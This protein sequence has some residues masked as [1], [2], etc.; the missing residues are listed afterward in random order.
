MKNDQILLAKLDRFIK[1]YYRNKLIRGIILSGAA[2]GAL[3]LSLVFI[4][5]LFH[6]NQGVRGI[7][8][9]GYIITALLLLIRQVFVPLV[10][11]LRYGK[12]ISYDQ[13]AT[14]IGEHFDEIRD[15][16]LNTLQ[17]IRES[18]K[19]A[20][21]SELLEASIDQKTERLKLIP[22]STA[23]DLKKN[24]KYLKFLLVQM[25]LISIVALVSPKIIS[26][27]THRI[28]QFTRS[29]EQPPKFSFQVL[30]KEL[31]V[32]QQDDLT[33]QVKVTGDELPGEVYLHTG[34]GQ[35]KMKKEKGIFF[36]YTF[37]SLQSSLQFEL[38]G[39]D[40]RSG[41]YT[42][43]V[44][45]KPII[46]NFQIE[47]TYP[48]HVNKPQETFDNVGDLFIPEGTVVTWTF[49]TKDVSELKMKFSNE[50]VDLLKN[51]G[52]TFTYSRRFLVSDHYSILP[53]NKFTYKPD[54]LSYKISVIND[55]YPSIAVTQEEDSTLM[56]LIFFQGVIK[57]D[58]GF[59]KMQ[60]GLETRQEG[61]TTM[62][63]NQRID[64]HVM[65]A[66]SSQQF[67]YT[68]DLTEYLIEHG[69]VVT[70]YFEVWDN[71]GVNGPK[72]SRT[73]KITI[74]LPTIEEI[75]S[76]TEKAE[77][78]IEKTFEAGLE[79]SKDIRKEI[80]E[81]NKKM[82]EKN[83]MSWQEKQKM[84]E[85][86]KA[87]E[88]ILKNIENIKEQNLKNIENEKRYLNTS[89][90]ILEKQKD[91]NALM[92]QLLTDEMKK[93][94]E[95]MKKLLGEMDK[96]KLGDLIEKMK[97]NNEDIEKQ[98]DRSLEIF[99]QIEFDRKI[100]KLIG[101]IRENAE[102]QEKAAEQTKKG[103]NK[104]EGEKEQKKVK[105][106]FDSISANLEKLTK[107]SELVENKPDMDKALEKQ[108][109]IEKKLKSIDRKMQEKK[110]KGTEKEQNEAAQ[111]M[112]EL[113]MEMEQSMEEDEMEQAEE[114]AGAI[115]MIL[116]NLVRLSH[117]QETLIKTTQVISK[118]DPRYNSMVERQ[119][120]MND[121][122]KGSEDSLNEIAKR[123]VLLQP[124]ISREIAAI[125]NNISLAIESMGNRML[126][127][128]VVQQQLVMTSI[129][130]LALLLNESLDKMN[131]QME[132][133]MSG[134]GKKSACKKPG[135][136]G[137]KGSMKNMKS[138]QQKL[139]E[140][141]EQL[142]SGM[143]KAKKE[144]KGDKLNETS[145]SRQ[146]AKLAAE[147]EF[148]RNE[149]QKHRDDMMEQGINDGGALKEVLKNMELNETDLI[150]KRISQ[151]TIKRQQMILTRMLE[152]EKAEQMREREEKRE[153]TEAKSR[154]YS[155]HFANLKYKVKGK[156][157]QDLL[158]LILP[159][160]NPYY[161]RKVNEYI[162]KIDR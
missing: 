68:M 79:K 26:E 88:T 12:I 1:K 113:A 157:E 145:M 75:E 60:V 92:D 45:P 7:F 50:I 41:E 137:G 61:D 116:E 149:M 84:E 129:N 82:V 4:E 122:L 103:N 95:E 39:G 16:L 130:N 148:L 156:N 24:L 72:S 69:E 63:K 56:H 112:N 81:L 21:K 32:M 126:K 140:Q 97:I 3:Y 34:G 14:I 87:H 94:M 150:N 36:S 48:K 47:A 74:A 159:G 83:T 13:A 155:N 66:L 55:G 152:S 125:R 19:G 124:V 153:S 85:I 70:C 31:T 93:L 76:K 115:R 67:N 5:Y 133:S 131:Q 6:F 107:E 40:I 30:N 108:D 10:H 106:K 22:F 38:Q 78:N 146:I 147:Q 91:L 2:L 35:Y 11:L 71:D 136:S 135:S 54:T 58:Y 28:V 138:M 80:D 59:T 120:E 114:D 141:L 73:D 98:L 9:F 100:E 119:K 158:Q 29:F 161:K 57:D 118:G 17:L 132:M 123:Q 102:M 77:K 139:G 127:N 43:T 111:Q 27:P 46:L 162:L 65:Q 142:R 62:L 151:E 8:L 64:I 89:E 18:E 143:E 42:I 53:R 144:G 37:K 104:S 160:I 23:I 51:K 90:R 117:E 33:L 110:G 101:D 105:E 154:E 15:K 86:W 44:Y 96:K 25:L 109:S 128:A 52:N 99:K 121:K 134:K 20:E 49:Y